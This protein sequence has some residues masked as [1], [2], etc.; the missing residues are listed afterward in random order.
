MK[1]NVKYKFFN[2]NTCITSM[3]FIDTNSSFMR[4]LHTKQSRFKFVQLPGV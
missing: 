3:Y 2:E 1:K 4:N